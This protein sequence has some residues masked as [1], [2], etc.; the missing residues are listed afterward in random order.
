MALN[1]YTKKEEKIIELLTKKI[2]LSEKAIEAKLTSENKGSEIIEK[3]FERITSIM[4]ESVKRNIKI[5]TEKKLKG[6]SIFAKL[7]SIDIKPKIKQKQKLSYI[8]WADAWKEVCKIYPDA[9]YEIIKNDNNLPY[10]KSDEGYMVFTKVSISNLT[11]EMWLPVM[12][13]ANKSMK[14][15]KYSYEVKDWEQSKKAGKDI[16]K[17][18]FVES[19]TMFDINKSI[20]R[21][22]VKNIAVFGLGLSLYNKDDIKDDWATISIEEYEKLKKLLD[23]SGTEEHKFLEHFKVDSLEEFK[24]SDFEKGLGMLKIKIKNKNASN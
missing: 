16:M 3:L 12:D 7:S 10:F 11:H 8:S 18:K 17:T 2:A 21:C 14:S 19:A 22:L 1:K 15:E 24:A 9:K 23:E 6:D 13:G 5:M 4:H 20:M